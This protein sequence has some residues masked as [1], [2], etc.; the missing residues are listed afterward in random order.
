[1]LLLTCVPCVKAQ[2]IYELKDGNVFP[3]MEFVEQI[4][5]ALYYEEHYYVLEENPQRVQVGNAEY[6]IRIGCYTP[7]YDPGDFDVIDIERCG[8][9]KYLYRDNM[10]ILRMNETSAC[11]YPR[12]NHANYK[13]R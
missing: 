4:S 10:G 13:F 7:H 6:L 12:S 1:M 5:D 2:Q 11:W 8:E 3:K 9:H